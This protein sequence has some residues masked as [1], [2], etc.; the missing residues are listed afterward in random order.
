MSP[1]SLSYMYIYGV[2]TYLKSISLVF[3]GALFKL[4]VADWLDYL[5]MQILVT[6]IFYF[7]A[8]ENTLHR[9]ETVFAFIFIPLIEPF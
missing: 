4:A 9:R 2:S 6:A 5:F 7:K 1:V 8:G 3:E